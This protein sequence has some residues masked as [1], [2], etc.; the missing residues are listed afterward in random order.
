M[1]AYVSPNNCDLARMH[2]QASRREFVLA[3][4]RSTCLRV[5]LIEKELEQIGTAL[6][7][8]LISPNMAL[9]WAEAVAPGCVGFIPANVHA[10]EGAE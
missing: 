3:A 4:L 7:E 8:Q 6:K 1:N 2:D 10:S 5:R 9:E